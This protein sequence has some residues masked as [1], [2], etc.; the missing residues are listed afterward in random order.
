MI[1]LFHLNFLFDTIGEDYLS[2]EEINFL[3]KN[4]GK[5]N[6]NRSKIPLL[7]KIFAFG[8]I[9]EKIGLENA[10]KLTKKDIEKWIGENQ[11][12]LKEQL[13]KIKAQAYLDVLGKQFKIE[14][15]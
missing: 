4:L 11:I 6:L 2:E 7:D 15:D 13:D 14:K 12:K 9:A 8:L 3:E 10:N 1:K 5:P